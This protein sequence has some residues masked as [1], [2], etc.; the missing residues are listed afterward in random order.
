MQQ[1][2]GPG[3]LLAD[4]YLLVDLL[5]ESGNGRFWRAH[6]R[7][8]ERHVALHCLAE[9]DARADDL[10]EAARVS[11]TVLDRRILRVLDA[12]RRGGIAY[13]VN[14][15]GSGTSLDHL[16]GAEGTLPPRRAAWIVCEVA[17]AMSVAHEQGVAHG[18]LVPENVL[19]DQTGQVRII[20]FCIDAAL[21]GIPPGQVSHDVDDL[22]GLL[23][24]LLTG[25]WAGPSQS[26]MPPALRDHGKWLRPR[27]VR[28]GIPRVLDT[29]CDQVLN[30]YSAQPGH[31]DFNLHTARGL[32]DVLA[33][34]V[35]DPTGLIQ[36]VGGMAGVL[37]VPE[38]RPP[39]RRH[40]EPEPAWDPEPEPEPGPEPE[41]EPEPEP[42]QV[43]PIT[44]EAEPTVAMQVPPA[45]TTPAPVQESPVDTPPA[46]DDMPT[47]AG[48]PI[49]DD[50]ADDVAW[51]QKRSE[52]PP[53]PPRFEDPPER[54]L[55]AP[56]PPEGTP[57]RT[58]R[59]GAAGPAT[60]EYWPWENTGPG[61]GSGVIPVVESSAE[62][63]EVPGRSWLRLALLIGFSLLL[64]VGVV[65]AYNLGRGKSPLGAE[66]DPSPSPRSSAPTSEPA[67]PIEGTT[68][69][70]LDPQGETPE[71]NSDQ[72]PLAVDGDPATAWPTSVYFDQFGPPAGLKTGVGLVVDLGE[73]REVSQIDLTT[74]GSPT[75]VTYYLTDTDPTAVAGLE[76]LAQDTVG[77]ER[78]RTRLDTPATGQ[79]LVVWITSLPAVG[80]DFRAEIAEVVVSQVGQ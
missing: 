39:S 25:K 74:V 18:R 2:A 49:F 47:Q 79:Y 52:P 69:R 54:P 45:T 37:A 56:T 72:A 77:Q 3:D 16:I 65:I 62:A 11:A 67:T 58:P 8:L 68:A 10:T 34:Y 75:D 17:A 53:P 61:T 80:A 59:P 40:P 38:R 5:T 24:F 76:P 41:A 78:L 31:Q 35:G 14:E 22:G 1:S 12:D 23:Y 9:N 64:L 27:Q 19:I 4:R 21:L 13:V 55:F 50:E 44:P 66:P 60:G 33:E 63:D 57:A 29:I 15:W 7:V 46:P 6:D 73:S 30:P 43:V 32:T 26:D 20:G 70:A 42:T 71:E 48:M 36:P 51:L 28:A